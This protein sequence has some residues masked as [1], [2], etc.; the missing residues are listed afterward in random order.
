MSKSKKI[1]IRSQLEITT[2][3]SKTPVMIQIRVTKD[4]QT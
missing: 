3:E 2:V 1:P 4:H